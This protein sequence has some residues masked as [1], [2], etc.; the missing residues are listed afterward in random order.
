M[1]LGVFNGARPGYEQ[2]AGL[3]LDHHLT[4]S[5]NIESRL[6]DLVTFNSG[7]HTAHHLHPGAHW[8]KLPELHRKLHDDIPAALR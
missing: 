8:S 3:D 6:Y 5:R 2:H 7:Y 4:A 1:P